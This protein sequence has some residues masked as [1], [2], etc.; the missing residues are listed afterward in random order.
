MRI[1]LNSNG[2]WL[3][4]GVLIISILAIPI[5]QLSGLDV[6]PGDIGD[7]RLN[8]YFLENIYQFLTGADNSLWHLSFFYPFPYVLGFSDNLFG[9]APIYVTARLFDA[10]PDTSFQIWFLWGYI[11]NFAAAYYALLRLGLNSSGAAM[12]ALIF[13]FVLPT[14][15]HA[16]HVQLHY[17]FG[18][19]LAFAYF[20]NFL[21][22]RQWRLFVVACGWIVW[23]FYCG[24]YIGFFTLLLIGGAAVVYAFHR[25]LTK[26]EH[27][28]GI[29]QPFF[30]SWTT[31]SW[32]EKQSLVAWFLLLAVLMGW[33]FYPY[34]QVSY[35]YG[36]SR[37]WAE[38]S[39]MLP[40]PQSYLGADRS[41]FWAPMLSGVL[42]DIP[43][44]HE[45][46]MFIGV[47]PLLLAIWG[48][49]L[50]WHARQRNT[51]I[52]ILGALVLVIGVTLYV[53]DW[54]PWYLIYKL[55]LFSAIRAMTRID[56][57]ILFIVGYFC[58][59]AVDHVVAVRKWFALPM[60]VAF[61][62]LVI[63]EAAH[64]DMPS[65]KKQSWRD[66][67]SAVE[68]EIPAEL[69]KG[70]V[71]FM[72]QRDG[73]PYADE[74]DSMWAAMIRGLRTVN[75]YS[76]NYPPGYSYEY[77][78]SCDEVSRRIASYLHFVGRSEDMGAAIYIKNR[79][80]LIGFNG[81]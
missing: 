56:L 70:D 64:V 32:R 58:A 57:A 72:A 63:V 46:Q 51:Y 15:A 25:F 13:S 45:H 78:S 19:P 33:L 68:N 30:I 80:H 16:G 41:R 21:E 9:A 48:G 10:L 49:V 61:F 77:G 74:L 67:I 38:I 28:T 11:L 50:G 26:T 43:M 17:R 18:L 24:I 8:N 42:K 7:S 2:L 12:G 69:V 76:G 40:R 81:C 29:F 27:D 22:Q 75:G 3:P 1:K 47:I 53:G 39:S 23:Q 62:L 31:L 71:I 6:M 60:A 4:V 65:S 44:R 52:F 35:L 54:S 34:I 37:E 79:I 14:T 5:N 59:I 73:P 55:P 36:A 20:L 66:R